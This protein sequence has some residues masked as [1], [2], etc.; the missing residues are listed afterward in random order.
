MQMPGLKTLRRLRVAGWAAALLLLA[1]A[2]QADPADATPSPI[3]YGSR[4]YQWNGMTA[5]QVEVLK[6]TGDT[7]RGKDAFRG[8][9]GCHR[10]E[11]LHDADDHRVQKE[12]AEAHPH[13]RDAQ[14][15]ELAFLRAGPV[16]HGLA[17]R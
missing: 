11:G 17:G 16:R 4:G 3:G 7:A 12:K 2:A 10:R 6:L 1:P 15:V 5:E 8:C 13:R 14:E 9:Q